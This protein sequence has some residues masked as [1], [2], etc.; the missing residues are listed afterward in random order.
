MRFSRNGQLVGAA[1]APIEGFEIEPGAA[2]FRIELDAQRDL[3]WWRHS[4]RVRSVWDFHSEDGEYVLPP[5]LAAGLTVP[6][7]D[8][9]NRVTTGKPTAIGLTLRHQSG[10]QASDITSAALELSYDGSTWTRL[11][12]RR[13]GPG[14][15]LT[16][17]THPSRQA[18]KAPSLRVTATDAAGGK[19][20]HEVSRAYTLVAR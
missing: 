1:E 9:L 12:L 20:T 8:V 4:T 18:G 10:S 17:V 15:Y 16:E 5:L 2:D 14:Q 6:R 3:P 19:L 13:S 7:A 11:P